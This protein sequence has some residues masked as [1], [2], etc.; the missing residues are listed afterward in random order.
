MEHNGNGHNIAGKEISL[1]ECKKEIEHLK[2][3]VKL[4]EE[5]IDV[6]RDRK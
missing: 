6:L 4:K 5:I 3:V 2:E 1:N